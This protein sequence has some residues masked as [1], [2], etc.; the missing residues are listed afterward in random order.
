[1]RYE[2]ISLPLLDSDGL[3]VLKTL[4]GEW[5]VGLANESGRPL[6]S[7][8]GGYRHHEKWGY[9]NW[10]VIRSASG[11][12]VV[13]RQP[14]QETNGPPSVTIFDS[15]EAIEPHVPP[16]VYDEAMVRAGLKERPQ[17]PEVPLEGI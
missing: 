5:L 4:E 11:K 10:Y 1:M 14:T 2:K 8:Q 12:I 7:L 17:F 6:V 13:Y 15:C 16:S 9:D 3:M